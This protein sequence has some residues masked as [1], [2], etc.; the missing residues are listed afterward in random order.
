M[1]V[2]L[3][4]NCSIISDL[5][6]LLL[7]SWYLCFSWTIAFLIF[8]FSFSS[9]INCIY[10]LLLSSFAWDFFF[11]GFR[12][13]LTV[14]WTGSGR[15]RKAKLVNNRNSWTVVEFLSF[16]MVTM[17]NGISLQL[18]ALLALLEFWF[19]YY[20]LVNYWSLSPSSFLSE[21]MIDSCLQ[22]IG[23]SNDI[24]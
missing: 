12:G 1:F 3:L 21:L 24:T 6:E 8:L 2:K 5:L 17:N 16:W 15:R 14:L 11:L 4:P 20:L 23:F 10:A 18:Q 22:V 7:I 13:M 9:V 19:V